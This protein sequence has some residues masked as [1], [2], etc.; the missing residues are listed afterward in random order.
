MILSQDQETK[1]IIVFTKTI[2]LGGFSVFTPGLPE[3][4]KLLFLIATYEH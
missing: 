2:H 3:K 1:Y 4:Q